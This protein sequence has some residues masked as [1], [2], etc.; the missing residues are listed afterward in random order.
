[1]KR[2]SRLEVPFVRETRGATAVV[3]TASTIQNLAL[4]ERYHV[5]AD[6]SFRTQGHRQHRTAATRLSTRL[7]TPSPHLFAQADPG[8]AVDGAPADAD[9][10]FPWDN[11]KT[12][13][14]KQRAPFPSTSFLSRAVS[15]RL[16]WMLSLFLVTS[17][18]RTHSGRSRRDVYIQ[19]PGSPLTIT[20]S[21]V[22][23][24]HSSHHRPNPLPLL[25]L[26]TVPSVHCANFT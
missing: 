26:P 16:V 8:E 15:D 17:V 25:D 20:S 14:S 3:F 19:E 6:D 12:T 22:Y 21:A 24:S 13:P 2:A 23:Y 11:N 18:S 1:M 9:R 5:L 10:R 7:S 4:R